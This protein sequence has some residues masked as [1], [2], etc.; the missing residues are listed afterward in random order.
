MKRP[1]LIILM[2]IFVFTTLVQAL[3]YYY[4]IEP[5][6]V[7]NLAPTIK[8]SS[9][10]VA[11]DK[12]LTIRMGG[13]ILAAV[14]AN[15][16]EVLWETPLGGVAIPDIW[17][18][19]RRVYV[20]TGER[21]ANLFMA[22][23]LM[24]GRRAYYT[25][26]PGDSDRSYTS[27]L[28]P[29]GDLILVPVEGGKLTAFDKN[30]GAEV[31]T[32]DLP[33][34]IEVFLVEEDVAYVCCGKHLMALGTEGG[35][36]IW[37]QEFSSEVVALGIGA[38]YLLAGVESDI[39]L[40]NPATG[41]I[42]SGSITLRGGNVV[43]GEIPC[44]RGLAYVMSTGGFLNI[45]DIAKG[46]IDRFPRLAKNA[47]DQPMIAGNALVFWSRKDGII[48]YDLNVDETS[49]IPEYEVFKPLFRVRLDPERWS[50]VFLNSSGSLM[51]IKLPRVGFVVQKLNAMENLTVFVE[52][53]VSLYSNDTI[54]PTIDVRSPEGDLLWL[55]VL[56][57]VTPLVRTRK[58]SFK[59]TLSKPFSYVE[60]NVLMEDGNVS[61]VHRI[62]LPYKETGAVTPKVVGSATFST[63]EL[64]TL[65][66]G[67][68][69][70][71]S[72][73]VSSNVSG[74]LELVLSGEGII[75]KTVSLGWVDAGVEKSFSIQTIPT[76]PGDVNI[77][78]VAKL[79][80][81]EIGET[82]IKG[83]CVQGEL[84]EGVSPSMV[85]VN[86]GETISLKVRVKNRLVDNAVLKIEASSDITNKSSVEV[87][88][89]KA[90]E[91]KEILLPLKALE[92]GSSEISVKVF[93]EDEIL[94]Q[95]S[96]SISVG[97]GITS[98]SPTASPTPTPTPVSPIESFWKAL[99]PITTFFEPYIGLWGSRL[100][101][102][103]LMAGIPLAVV[104]KVISGR[105]KEKPAPTPPSVMEEIK[106]E[107]IEIIKPK[108]AE[109]EI[110][111]VAP[112]P[113]AEEEK[114][115]VAVEAPTVYKELEARMNQ[116]A[117]KL[118]SLLQR[119]KSYEEQGFPGLV[120]KVESL[121]KL[122][123]DVRMEISDGKYDYAKQLLD[124]LESNMISLDRRLD[125][126]EELIGSWSKIEG[127]IKMMLSLWGK[128]PASLLTTLPEDLRF[129]ALVRFAKLH[130]EMNLE[131]KGDE[132][133]LLEE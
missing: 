49:Y 103:A 123:Y 68:T 85:S 120:N 114:P 21:T 86:Q 69:F 32:V 109:I 96:V 124:S 54:V 113:P 74:Q 59:F 84:L 88:P 82:A 87:G 116:V 18:D 128:A 70:E 80:G 130:P 61:W 7:G 132:L 26:I 56:P 30:N 77:R 50:L 33:G 2:L 122:L 98:P 81:T 44:R 46:E 35:E 16:G 127:R 100:V 89:L 90:G 95:M 58:T 94:D 55:E 101:V 42:L 65:T 64:G 71:V 108:P 133:I 37:D 105:R 3:P 40:V 43:A 51:S 4:T 110:V 9:P 53:V 1:L 20:T 14:D 102:L 75:S 83:T 15:T 38:G 78:L 31:W 25:Q 67:E 17:A 60:L 52:G 72:G 8:R 97:V 34:S 6:E 19:W 121:H 92:K 57:S 79:N 27:S 63:S 115:E 36:V 45:I 13:T 129:I 131:I 66:V 118:A 104:L 117:G 73:K 99:A 39:Y 29:A 93:R 12:I 11:R 10:F 106:P 23:D 28:V 111:P 41:E 47:Y 119:A 76:F 48:L 5:I 91:D 62:E 24:T 125:S 112:S 126:L 107:E 22:F